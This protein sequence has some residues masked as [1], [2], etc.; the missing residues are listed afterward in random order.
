V[1]SKA[2][3]NVCRLGRFWKCRLWCF[4]KFYGVEW[5]QLEQISYTNR[6][7]AFRWKLILPPS[8]NK[9]LKRKVS[10]AWQTNYRTLNWITRFSSRMF[11][12]ICQTWHHMNMS[13]RICRRL[14]K[15]SL[16]SFLLE[17]FRCTLPAPGTPLNFIYT[18]PMQILRMLLQ[19]PHQKNQ[20]LEGSSWNGHFSYACITPQVHLPYTGKIDLSRVKNI[21]QKLWL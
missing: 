15:S 19:R 7:Q 11:W 5:Q 9:I 16:T 21:N 10:G 3:G 8:Q 17:H 12:L 14:A 1:H 20:L 4:S 2:F 18:K 13:K 6:S